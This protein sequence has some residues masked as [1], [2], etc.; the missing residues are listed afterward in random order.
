MDPVSSLLCCLFQPRWLRWPSQQWL[1]AGPGWNGWLVV[2]GRRRGAHRTERRATSWRRYQSW[3]NEAEC[4]RRAAPVLQQSGSSLQQRHSGLGCYHLVNLHEGISVHTAWKS[5]NTSA[6]TL[7][8]QMYQIPDY[9]F[10]AGWALEAAHACLYCSCT[11]HIS[12]IRQQRQLLCSRRR[13]FS[14]IITTRLHGRGDLWQ[15]EVEIQLVALTKRRLVHLRSRA[16]RFLRGLW[17]IM[18][19][20]WCQ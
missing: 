3:K 7:E 11:H 20:S 1:L 13:R 4:A 16:L 12:H 5:K 18:A 10:L 19:V 8:W 14:L 2:D 9:L 17:G 6:S 15:K